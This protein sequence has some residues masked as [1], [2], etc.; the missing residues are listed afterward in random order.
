[1]TEETRDIWMAYFE[2][3]EMKS[4]LRK[5]S[6]PIYKLFTRINSKRASCKVWN[7]MEWNRGMEWNGMSFWNGI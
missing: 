3:R 5:T 2:G 7:G 1:M 6:I 4:V